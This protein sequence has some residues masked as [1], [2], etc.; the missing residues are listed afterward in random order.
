MF[1][2]AP[3]KDAVWMVMAS[4]DSDDASLHWTLGCLGQVLDQCRCDAQKPCHLPVSSGL[5]SCYEDTLE[6]TAD[7]CQGACVLG[8]LGA[9]ALGLQRM[10]NL[11]TMG[12]PG[13]WSRH[14]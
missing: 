8:T 6:Q 12:W 14:G 10:L 5:L 2:E 11:N 4:Q 13:A 9:R 1:S 7:H 3:T